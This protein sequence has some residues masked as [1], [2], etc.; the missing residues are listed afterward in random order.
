[1]WSNLTAALWV[2]FKR[3]GRSVK[4]KHVWLHFSPTLSIESFFLSELIYPPQF[5]VCH[6]VV[7]MVIS[8]MVGCNAVK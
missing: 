3:K 4:K 2:S 5:P 1:M 6:R 7:T 8:L